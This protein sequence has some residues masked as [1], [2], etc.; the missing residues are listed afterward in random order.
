MAASHS[1]DGDVAD[2]LAPIGMECDRRAMDW[3]IRLSAGSREGGG[4]KACNEVR[5]IFSV[6]QPVEKPRNAIGI[7][8]RAA[9]RAM[10]VG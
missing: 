3:P 10:G 8:Q 7:A 5:R 4:R 1:R 2:E 6:L 9:P